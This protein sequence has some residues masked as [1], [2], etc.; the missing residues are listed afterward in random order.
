M[1]TIRHPMILGAGL[2]LATFPGRSQDR[3]TESVTDDGRSRS[4]AV[5]SAKTTPEEE[6]A[7]L[8][9]RQEEARKLRE[10]AE[11]QVTLEVQDPGD[12]WGRESRFGQWTGGRI[13]VKGSILHLF[14]AEEQKMDPRQRLPAFQGWDLRS[15]RRILAEEGRESFKS[16]FGQEGLARMDAL[17]K[18]SDW[19]VVR[20]LKIAAKPLATATGWDF[21]KL[22]K[23]MAIERNRQAYEML[24]G[25]EGLAR[26]DE[27]VRKQDWSA[28]WLTVDES[29]AL[30][31]LSYLVGGPPL[32][33]GQTMGIRRQLAKAAARDAAVHEAYQACKAKAGDATAIKALFDAVGKCDDGQD[34]TDGVYNLIGHDGWSDRC[35]LTPEQC[36]YIKR[37]KIKDGRSG[38]TGFSSFGLSGM[39]STNAGT[40][41]VMLK[42][43]ELPARLVLWELIKMADR[44]FGELV[45]CSMDRRLKQ[46]PITA[47]LQFHQIEDALEQLAGLVG[48]VLEQGPNG[49]RIVRRDGT[50]PPPPLD[51]QAEEEKLARMIAEVLTLFAQEQFV[52]GMN[53]AVNPGFMKGMAN[54]ILPGK[55][56]SIAKEIWLPALRA[57][58]GQPPTFMNDGETAF[59]EFKY[60]A[61]DGAQAEKGTRQYVIFTLDSGRWA[62]NR[63]SPAPPDE[64]PMPGDAPGADAK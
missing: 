34:A 14:Y 31:A 4:I 39:V 35:V 64:M 56:A 49:F 1:R 23:A 41:T 13:F 43:E 33:P 29:V 40:V 61:G 48:G 2:L 11:V 38:A 45:T 17:L 25:Q 24:Y 44:H 20:S 22:D 59:Y 62:L 53:L 36:R 12:T 8:K 19:S 52:D 55:T 60:A 63:L 18:N 42:I 9:Q 3:M 7:A 51:L 47:N 5:S 57:I 32:T 46:T 50:P 15:L 54:R 21:L 28:V 27:A 30:S 10:E 26:A 16:R 58:H 37:Q 6:A